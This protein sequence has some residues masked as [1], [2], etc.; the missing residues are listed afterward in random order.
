MGLGETYNF[1]KKGEWREDKRLIEPNDDP[2]Q[3]QEENQ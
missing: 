2:I 1:W 3:N